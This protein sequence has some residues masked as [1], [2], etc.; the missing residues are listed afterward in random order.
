[1]NHEKTIELQGADGWVTLPSSL[2]RPDGS[3]RFHVNFPLTFAADAGAQHLVVSET[4]EG[5]EPPTRD[6]L[7]RT[8]RRGDLF[9][10][11]GAHWGFFSL[12]AATH[13][14]GD[15][16]VVAFEPD[17]INATTLTE[18][19]R[20]NG[21][22][23]AVT[24]ICAACGD[25]NELAPLV[26]NSTMGHSIRGVGLSPRARGPAK[27]VPVV[28]LD[29]ALASLPAGAERRIVLKIDAEGLEP[30]IIL[31]AQS[32]LARGRVALIVWE[33]GRAFREGPMRAAMMHM[34]A[35]LDA[36]GFRHVRPAE[37]ARDS[38]PIRFDPQVAYLGNVFS[39][40][41]Q[42]DAAEA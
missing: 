27:W 37:D 21:L 22:T 32:L 36:R 33:C 23:D 8:L 34:V 3:S 10:D 11:V 17:V 41:R 6:L 7:E 19:V 39:F 2:K 13:P 40:A 12:Q 14:S 42:L 24:V 29:G 25:K 28:T 35:L 1:M 16:A 30:N 15:V 38:A 18:N 26:T 5:Y 31:G 9:I 20:R 4:G